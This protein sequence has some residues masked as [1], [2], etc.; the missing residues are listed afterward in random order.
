MAKWN[1]ITACKLC[2][3]LGKKP[4]VYK[5]L[6]N[7]LNLTE[8]EIRGW[9]KTASRISINT[10]KKGVIEQFDG[11]FRLKKVIPSETDE[12]GIPLLPL[13][14]KAK[15]LGKTQLVKQADVL[16]LLVLL[17]DVFNPKTKKTNYDFYLPRTVHK[18]SLSPSMHA[19]AACS[20]FDL[21]RAYN[22][23][24]VA[25][26]ADISNLYGNTPEG[27][28]AACLGGTWQVV[29][30]GFAGVTITKNELSINPS[31]PRSWRKIAFSFSWR[32]SLVKL[33]LTSETVRLRLS[34][35]KRGKGIRLR[36]FD[37]PVFL[38]TNKVYIFKKE[39]GWHRKEEYY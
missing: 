28:H 10:D 5:K 9:M 3:E 17:E 21:H 33:E 1:L 4:A 29:F 19:L 22:F 2:R 32:A 8:K 26:R 14:I 30:S 35:L 36:V 39:A 23:F 15:D 16:M 18:S 24:N 38:K 20:V 27:I 7:K 25:L 12:N 34:G 11:Y 37:K 6:K 31:I 13:N